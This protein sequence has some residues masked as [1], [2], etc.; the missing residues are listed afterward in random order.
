M[1]DLRHEIFIQSVNKGTIF[2]FKPI[3]DPVINLLV[4]FKLS[5]ENSL[6][7]YKFRKTCMTITR[8][9]YV[10]FLALG[11]CW[12]KSLSRCIKILIEP[13]LS[14][15]INPV[16][17]APL[18]IVVEV[19]TNTALFSLVPATFI[20]TAI[21]PDKLALAVTLVL[22]KLALVLLAVWPH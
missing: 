21:A 15:S 4:K 8:Q 20:F 1:F 22:F 17:F 18:L 12:V 19:E 10:S 14:S 13:T 2:A 11:K 16:A 7:N 3:P 6:H 9:L 5:K